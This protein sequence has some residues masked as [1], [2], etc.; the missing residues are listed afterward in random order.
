MRKINLTLLLVISISVLTSAQQVNYNQELFDLISTKKWF[1]IDQYYHQHKDSINNEFV[2]L[3]YVAETSKAFNQ[4]LQSIDAYEQLLE[5]N[6]RNED[7]PTLI[8]GIGN[9]LLHICAREQE[10]EK[11]EILCRKMIN[12]VQSDTTIE[13]PTLIH[14]LEIAAS[15]FNDWKSKVIIPEIVDKRSYNNGEVELSPSTSDNGIYFNAQ[16]NGVDLRTYFD[17]GFSTCYIFNRATAERIGVK[18]NYTDTLLLNGNTKV[19][20]GTIDSLILGKFII[21]NVPVCVNIESV[22]STN[23][24]QTTCDSLLNSKFDVVLGMPIIKKLGVIEFNFAKNTMSF[25]KRNSTSCKRNIYI[26]GS[27]P[28]NGFGGQ[29]YMN[30]KICNDNFLTFFDTGGINGLFI[31]TDFFE[32]H[33]GNIPIEPEVI[34]HSGFVGGCSGANTY[35][36][37]QYECN[38]IEIQINDKE[39][40][41]LNDCAIA[42]DK[43]NDDKNGTTEGNLGSDIFKYCNKAIFDFNNMVF[44]V[45]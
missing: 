35:T 4:P 19:L 27:S 17:T 1:E 11:G 16:W 37:Y 20:T 13:S 8:S 9:Y 33:R 25:P 28:I 22:D 41:M 31:N 36:R 18:F 24:Y 30:L 23:H 40:K 43:E 29:L 12:L 2:K 3:L 14:D 45:E 5:K 44:S 42:K 32:K 21:S 15:T 7:T 34:S 26:N 6:L 10:F 39:I 38:Q